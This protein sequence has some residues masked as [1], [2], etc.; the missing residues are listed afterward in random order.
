VPAAC[1]AFPLFRRVAGTEYSSFALDPTLHVSGCRRSPAKQAGP[2]AEEPPG[3]LK[4]TFEPG[5]GMLRTRTRGALRGP[6]LR[7]GPGQGML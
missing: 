7:A 3:W 6:G 4:C 1:V 2:P 5:R